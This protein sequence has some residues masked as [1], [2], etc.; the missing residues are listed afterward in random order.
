[1]DPDFRALKTALHFLGGHISHRLWF[2]GATFQ[3]M[4]GKSRDTEGS[5]FLEDREFLCQLKASLWLCWI[6]LGCMA[7]RPS[8]LWSFG[9]TLQSGL[10]W[11][12]SVFL[13]VRH[14]P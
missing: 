13:S 4:S 9:P 7:A 3:P 6:F 1:M 2:L 11:T 12:L 10:F 8:L 14:V 5:L